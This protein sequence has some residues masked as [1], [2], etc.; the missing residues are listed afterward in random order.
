MAESVQCSG[1]EERSYAHPWI[2]GAYDT[3]DIIKRAVGLEVLEC[4][5][6]G[7]E[8]FDQSDWVFALSDLLDQ[9]L[10]RGLYG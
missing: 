8:I 3:E 2:D 10:K 7:T 9:L 5:R 6:C 1:C 4:E